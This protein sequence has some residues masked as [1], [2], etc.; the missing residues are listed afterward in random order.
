MKNLAQK[1]GETLLEKGMKLA[2]AESCTGGWVAQAVTAVPG[3]S[4]WFDCG[5]VS[6]SN[7]AK[8]KMLGVEKDVLEQHGA[9]SEPVV[10]QM[11]EPG[12]DCL[13]GLGDRGA[14][15]GYLPEFL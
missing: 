13:D 7:R 12:G 2:T 3:S 5:F 10:A 6:Y 1:V 8:Q 14:P 15:D 9:V 11:A 4:G